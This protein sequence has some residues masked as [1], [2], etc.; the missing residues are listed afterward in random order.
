MAR[1]EGDR[2][3]LRAL[4]EGVDALVEGVATAM[5]ERMPVREPDG[6]AQRV[7]LTRRA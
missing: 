5:P 3:R 2:E 1:D 4:V 7:S 6:G